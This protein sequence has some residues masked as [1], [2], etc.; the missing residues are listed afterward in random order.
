MFK[1]QVEPRASGWWFH[2]KGLNIFGVISMVYKSIDHEK[3][4]LNCV[5]ITSFLWFALLS[6]IAL[7]QSAS[8]KSLNYCKNVHIMVNPFTMFRYRKANHFID[9]AKLLFKVSTG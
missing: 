9:A 4:K 2:C 6:T 5:T 7:D 1:T 8:E 3:E